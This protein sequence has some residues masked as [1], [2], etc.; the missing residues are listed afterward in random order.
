MTGEEQETGLSRCGFPSGQLSDASGC[1]PKG[2]G[3]VRHRQDHS[4]GLRLPAYLGWEILH[5]QSSPRFSIDARGDTL[6]NGSKPKIPGK[7]DLF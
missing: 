7:S 2:A 4:G 1:D 3:I 6:G 5:A